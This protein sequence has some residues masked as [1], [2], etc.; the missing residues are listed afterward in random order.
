[1]RTLLHPPR[2]LMWT[3]GWLPIVSVRSG[4]TRS[5][6]RRGA[7][8]RT[9]L[10]AVT[11]ACSPPT[12]L[13]GSLRG[14][15]GRDGASDSVPRQVVGQ[16]QFLD[17]IVQAVR[18]CRLSVMEAFGRISSSA[19][20]ASSRCSHLEI[21]TLRLRPRF[22]QLVMVFG[23]CLWSTAYWIFREIL[24]A[25]HLVRLWK[26]E[27]LGEFQHFLRCCELVRPPFGLNGE[28]CPVDASGCSFSQRG[29]HVGC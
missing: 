8:L 25:P 4:T 20:L 21:W 19:L 7:A 2:Q 28:V 27:A 9:A 12:T 3:S 13:N 15:A 29:S 5:V 23:C 24:R 1:M 6:S 22:F 11:G 10:A 18:G 16:F 17:K 14:S 26:H